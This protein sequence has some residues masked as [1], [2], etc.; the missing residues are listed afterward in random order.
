MTTGSKAILAVGLLVAFFPIPSRISKAVTIRIVFADGRPAPTRWVYQDWEC[1]GFIGRG[2][3][4]RKPDAAGSV[5]FPARYGYGSILMRI[6]GRL[7][8][9]APHASY[10]ANVH[11]SL[12][13][14]D[15]MRMVF[16]AA[17]YKPLEPFTTS[18]SYLDGV[19]RDYLL[20]EDK[21]GQSVSISWQS[22]KQGGP[23]EIVVDPKPGR[24]LSAGAGV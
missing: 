24:F 12:A 5:Q 17:T 4:E 13:L 18:H 21:D 6:C 3:E 11:L 9:L 10:G 16:N 7:L 20:Q 8:A 23:I 19:G 2:F 22:G 15:P 14:P 1:F